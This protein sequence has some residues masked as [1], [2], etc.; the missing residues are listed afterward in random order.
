MEARGTR[1]ALGVWVA[2]V[3]AFLYVPI[4]V[5]C[6]YAFNKSNV[7]SWPID[8]LTTKWFSPAIHNGDMQQAL[9]LSLKAG[10]LA[11]LIALVLGSAASFGVH[12]FRF[13]G[14]ALPRESRAKIA[15][16]RRVV[17]EVCGGPAEDILRLRVLPTHDRRVGARLECH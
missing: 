2:L 10:A 9:L 7:Q 13:F 12:R 5:I 8:V 14:P 11:T 1:I 3:L 16:K 15:Q 17:W 6:L 4:I